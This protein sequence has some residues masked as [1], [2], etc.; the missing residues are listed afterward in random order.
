MG[1]PWLST[2]DPDRLSADLRG[3][4][5]DEIE[6]LDREAVVNWLSK[7]RSEVKA[8]GPHL[9]RARRTQD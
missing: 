5:Y 4:G 6:D 2:F 8:A 9:L 1:E 7:T 3:L